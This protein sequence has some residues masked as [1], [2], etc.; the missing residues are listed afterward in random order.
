MASPSAYRS[1]YYCPLSWAAV[2]CLR[3]SASAPSLRPWRALGKHKQKGRRP[4]LTIRRSVIRNRSVLSFHV[5]P[6]F[7]FLPFLNDV[8]VSTR[9]EHH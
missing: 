9:F 5:S 7:F 4:L 8:L 1:T 3:R 2:L 6:P